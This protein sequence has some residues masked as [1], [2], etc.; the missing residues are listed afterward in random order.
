MC[1]RGGDS[2]AGCASLTSAG[3][4]SESM[5]FIR[6]NLSTENSSLSVLMRDMAALAPG[7]VSPSAKKKGA[8]VRWK[9]WE[10]RFAAA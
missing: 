2:I 8:E 9:K 7:D 3:L 5:D 1:H 4:C 10:H 6:R